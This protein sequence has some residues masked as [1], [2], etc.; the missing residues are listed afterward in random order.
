MNNRTILEGAT[1]LTPPSIAF[2]TNDK[3]AAAYEDDDNIFTDVHSSVINTNADTDYVVVDDNDNYDD[4]ADDVDDLG[5][6][7]WNVMEYDGKRYP[8]EILD[9]DVDKLEVTVMNHSQQH[10]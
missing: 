9:G 5:S 4:D 2:S 6:S 1:S 7:F 3:T 10:E 8:D